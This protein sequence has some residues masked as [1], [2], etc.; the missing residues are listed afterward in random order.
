M[1]WQ[2]LKFMATDRDFCSAISFGPV[3]CSKSLMNFESCGICVLVGE[4]V[5]EVSQL[6]PF[7]ILWI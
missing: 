4:D 6:C 5:F 7:N 3:V 2:Y 1:A